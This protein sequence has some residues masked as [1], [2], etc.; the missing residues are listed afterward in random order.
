[1][2]QIIFLFLSAMCGGTLLARSLLELNGDFE[3]VVPDADSSGFAPHLASAGRD[4]AKAFKEGQGWDVK[5]VAGSAARRGVPAIY[6]GMDFA[7]KAGLVPKE[8]LRGFDNVVAEKNGS[9]YLFGADRAMRK[10]KRLD[11]TECMLPTVKATANFMERFLGVRF[12]GPGDVGTDIPKRPPEPMPVGFQS[13]ENPKFDAGTGRYFTMTYS[14]ANNIFGAGGYHSWGGHA[15]LHAVPVE[16]YADAHPEYYA[17]RGGARKAEKGNPALCISNPDVKKLLVDLIVSKMDDGADVVEL[18]QNDGGVFCECDKCSSLYG[19]G[20]GDVGEKIWRFHASVAEAVGRL[21]PGKT[22]QILSYGKTK[23]PPRTMPTLPANVMVEL[24][25]TSPEA[26]KEWRRCKVPGGFSAYVYL[27][28]QWPQPGATAKC[29]MARASSSAKL[30][31][32]SGVR[33]IYR[34]GC[35]ELFGTE[36]PS[37]Y[38]YNRTLGDA[39][40]D[41]RA[42]VDEYCERAYG[43][44]A[45][46]P[47]REFFACLDSRLAGY[48][49]LFA[50]GTC[51]K[52]AADMLAYIYTPDVM[53]TLESRLSRAEKCRLADKQRIRLALVRKEFDYAKKTATVCHLYNASRLRPSEASVSALAGAL[54]ERNEFID[55]LYDEKGA[56][57]KFPGWPEVKVFGNYSRKVMKDNGQIS[58]ILG[59]PFG[60]D[61]SKLSG[62]NMPGGVRR[63]LVV[64]RA[65]SRPTLVAGFDS[66]EW[67]KA[68]YN[69]LNGMQLEKV[70]VGAGFKVL[71]DDANLYFGVR[72]TLMDAIKFKHLGRDGACFRNHCVEIFV[73]PHGSREKWFHFTYNPV[74][75]SFADEAT[76]LI[77][78]RLDPKYGKPDIGWNGDWRYENLRGGNMWYSLV[79][80][81]FATLGVNTPE[82]GATMAANVGRETPAAAGGE[83]LLWSPNFVS[84]Q[85]DA[86][87]AFGDMVF[88]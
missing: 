84:R 87:E 32:E 38:V 83:L 41:W 71:Y 54:A 76:G 85:F 17:M 80:I 37:Y 65:K 73:D 56:S 7:G 79:T 9:I 51:P 52:K 82:P 15:Y 20:R 58:A 3:I 42:L 6:L 36:G 19:L 21:R 1:M 14:I 23:D 72:S 62:G 49:A 68:A 60:W 31:V 74:A 47:M 29:S 57:R 16:K 55:A 39:S 44:D 22:V 5:V 26:F 2:R 12:L 64:K 45:A 30:M 43:P 11:W 34:C 70:T 33:S 63:R 35:G 88:E 8:P 18:G 25:S 40:L 13:R 10:K 53:E 59:A 48:D 4:L 78:D 61:V 77:T 81:P 69:D 67:K 46:K 24:T 28:G 86:P 75:D 27:W 66:G 50:A